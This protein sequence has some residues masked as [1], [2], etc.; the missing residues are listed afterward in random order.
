MSK[1]YSKSEQ[2]LERALKTVPLG[3]QTFSKSKTQ[4]PLGVSPYFIQKGKGSHVWD[5][6]GN[7]YVDSCNGLAAVTLG[8]GDPDVTAAVKQQLE[9]GVIF[10]LPSP[11]EIEVAEK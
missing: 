3:S 9:D 11:L 8:Y 7:E 2:L 4:F 1:R 10:S 5:V 6:D